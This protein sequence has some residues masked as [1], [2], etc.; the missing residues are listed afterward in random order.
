MTTDTQRDQIL[1]HLMACNPITPLEALHHF[2]CMRLGARI[3]ELKQPK[4]GSHPITRRMK[5]MSSGK[6]VAEYSYDFSA[7]PLDRED[8]AT[9]AKG[10]PVC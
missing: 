6:I 9:L 7:A 2:K 1:K 10:A 4:Y 8:A 5:T 3:W